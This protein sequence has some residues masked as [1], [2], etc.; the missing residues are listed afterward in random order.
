MKTNETEIP[1]TNHTK[2]AAGVLKQ[3]AQD[4]RRFHQA[5]N[6]TERDL[7]LDAESWVL[8]DDRSWSFSFL[9]VC[10]LLHR[11]PEELRY[12][13]LGE[14]S[15]SP[16]TQWARRCRRAT[17]RLRT[18]LVEHFRGEHHGATPVLVQP[19]H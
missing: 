4:L 13:L 17:H 16:M 7:Y 10:G 3:A 6:S 12:E 19:V 14:L 2:L 11:A 5:H 1:E 18:R 15:L 8:S 9:N